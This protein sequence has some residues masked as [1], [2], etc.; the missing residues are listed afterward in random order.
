MNTQTTTTSA[1]FNTVSFQGRVLNVKVVDGQYGEFA[2]ITVITNLQA[3]EDK[4]VTLIFNNGNGL[5][6]LFKTG[7]LPNGRQVTVTGHLDSIR[8]SYEKDGELVQL[9]RPE[10][11]LDSKTVQVHLGAMPAEKVGDMTPGRVVKRYQAKVAPTVDAT[12]EVAEA[13]IF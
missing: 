2:A 4:A 7:W 9:K 6:S 5:L 10:I 3:S 13:P 11:Q 12:P 1:N 8:T